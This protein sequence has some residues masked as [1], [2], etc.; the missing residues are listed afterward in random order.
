MLSTASPDLD[1]NGM[2]WTGRYNLDR[3]LIFK[4]LPGALLLVS[5]LPSTDAV[6]VASS[7]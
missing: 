4:E 1:W 3:L 5:W 7:A 6:V 2:E